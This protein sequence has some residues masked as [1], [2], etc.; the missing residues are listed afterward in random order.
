LWLRNSQAV[1]RM[2]AKLGFTARSHIVA[3]LTFISVADAT[4]PRARR[5]SLDPARE[6]DRQ[7]SVCSRWAS[8]TAEKPGPS[9]IAGDRSAT[10]AGSGDHSR[11]DLRRAEEGDFCFFFRGF[12]RVGRDRECRGNSAS[13]GPLR[14]NPYFPAVSRPSQDAHGSGQATRAP[15][16]F[17][18]TA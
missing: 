4:R 12:L 17:P 10:R 7:V 15:Q 9:T 18:C 2:M 3:N 6:P 1:G 5:W 13:G 8:A 11:E 16:E 14:R